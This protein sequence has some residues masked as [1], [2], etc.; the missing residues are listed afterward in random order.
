MYKMYVW[1]PDRR[2]GMG[3]FAKK[4][5]NSIEKLKKNKKK[6]KKI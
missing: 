2:D 5:K 1:S 4:I 6:L 3:G